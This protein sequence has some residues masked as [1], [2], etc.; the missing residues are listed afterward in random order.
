MRLRPALVVA[1][2]AVGWGTIGVIVRQLDLPAVAIVASRLWIGALTLG[3]VLALRRGAGRGAPVDRAGRTRTVLCGLVLAGHWVALVAALQ[4]APIG[5]V[6][7]V[8]YLAPVGVAVLAPRT[9]GEVVE[10]V[11]VAALAL[12]VVGVALVAWPSLGTPDAEGLVLAGVA[13]ALL[14]FLLL[15]NKPLAVAYSALPLA[16]TQFLVAGAALVPVA[17]FAGW[18]SPRLAWLWLVVLGVVHTALADV[19]FLGALA[20]MP[21]SRA[22]VLLYLEP[23]S[24]VAFGWLLLGEVPEPAMVAGG[25]LIVLAGVLVARTAAPA[26]ARVDAGLAGRPEVEVA[27]VPR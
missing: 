26:E 11:T 6:L 24:A 21:A 12:A 7:L 23:A 16:F 18:G 9:L 19:L 13:G 25:V 17:A 2:V 14:V 20:R 22:G 5:V 8:T 27:G 4:Q 10:P 1:G 3:L 15:V